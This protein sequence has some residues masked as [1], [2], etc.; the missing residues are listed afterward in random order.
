[1]FVFVGR[2]LHGAYFVWAWAVIALI[3][4][5]RNNEDNTLYLIIF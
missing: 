2:T 4:G 5:T 3:L 1:M